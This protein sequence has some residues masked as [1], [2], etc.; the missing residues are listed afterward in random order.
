MH[1]LNTGL[2][3]AANHKIAFTADYSLSRIKE[4]GVEKTSADISI[5][6]LGTRLAAN[7]RLQLSGFYQYNSFDKRARLNL[8]ASWEFAPLSFV[9]LVLNDT[10]TRNTHL[11]NQSAIAKVS[12][13][14]QF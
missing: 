13:L 12:Y 11:R 9:Y 5:Y 10:E 1:E 8:R 14:K 6:T 3:F 2:R 4:L 7:P